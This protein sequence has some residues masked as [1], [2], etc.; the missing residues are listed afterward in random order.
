MTLLTFVRTKVNAFTNYNVFTFLYCIY[1]SNYGNLYSICYCWN[2]LIFFSFNGAYFIDK[3]CFK[4]LAYKK[5]VSLITFH[6]GNFVLHNIPFIYVNYYLPINVNFYHS[7]GASILHFLW[8]FISTNGSMDLK[9]I[10]VELN[11]K[12]LL[13]VYAISFLS[14]INAPITF[15]II[16]YLTN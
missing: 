10:Y 8:C 1:Y 13:I 4:R 7:F 15:N 5:K 14:C 3:T 16:K 12:N 9:N 2:Y 6:I 11:Y